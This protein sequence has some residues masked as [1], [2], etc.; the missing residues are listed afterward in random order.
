M[1]DLPL[2]DRVRSAEARDEGTERVMFNQSLDWRESYRTAAVMFMASLSPGDEFIGEDLRIF[3]IK[4]GIAAPHHQ[5]AWGAMARTTLSEWAK[6]ARI[7]IVGV[8]NARSVSAHAR[9]S[10][11]YRVV[12]K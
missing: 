10:P 8:R 6:S 12:T 7:K 11:I 1:T 4:T 2:F 9:L 5:N 3:A